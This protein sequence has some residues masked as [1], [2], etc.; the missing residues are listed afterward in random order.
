MS[1]LT[2][3]K[4]MDL[5]AIVILPSIGVRP[6]AWLIGANEQGVMTRPRGL[7]LPVLAAFALTGLALISAC[8]PRGAKNWPFSIGPQTN[9][10]ALGD[11]DGDG[12]LDAFHANGENEVPVPNTVWL[13]DGQGRF[14]DSGQQ[15]EERESHHVILADI[16][17]NG[18][19]DAVVGEVGGLSIFRNSHSTPT[20]AVA[21]HGWIP[22]GIGTYVTTPA[23]GDVN[24]DG[25]PDLLAG[26]CCGAVE[27][28]QDGGRI[29]YPPTD[30]L[31]INYGP[32]RFINSGQTFDHFG[33]RSI[34]LGDLDGDGDLDAFFGNSASNLDQTEEFIRNQ[35]DTVW[36]NNGQ[37]RFTDSGQRLGESEAASV[38][39]G[40]LDGDGDPDVLVGNQRQEDEVWLNAGGAQ[41]GQPGEFFLAETIG[42]DE[43]TR[44][45][46][47]ADLD[48]DGDLDALTVYN[49]RGFGQIWRRENARVWFND[50]SAKFTAGQRLTFKPQHALALGDLNGDGHVDVYAGSVNHG[51][52]VW[53]NDGAGKFKQ[54]P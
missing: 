6:G 2:N 28:P 5:H 7:I 41:G 37:G 1:I 44:S 42:S 53:F 40:D 3:L 45:L 38:A 14:S 20:A 54:Q 35:P 30:S 21:Q 34:V 47:L 9:A 46:A 49:N 11:L 4:Q 36:F 43:S 24:S 22:S 12:D 18:G 27:I 31:W 33:T 50:G 17:L 23:V 8:A 10:V 25:Y 52:L 15:I 19:L 29:V 26:G 48:G 51:V 16:D 13:N 39:L 32:G